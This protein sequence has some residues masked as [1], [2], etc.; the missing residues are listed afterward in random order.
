[1]W[2]KVRC[3]VGQAVVAPGGRCSV[4]STQAM[5]IDA[6]TPELLVDLDRYPVLDPDAAQYR[7]VV[8][9]AAPRCALW[10]RRN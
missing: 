1:M 5:D 3:G 6:T 4:A 9:E 10:G 2:T 8:D 7:R